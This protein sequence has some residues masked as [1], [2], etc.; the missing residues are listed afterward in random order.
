MV[1]ADKS[2]VGRVFRQIRR[3]LIANDGKP[4]LIRQLLDYITVTT[5]GISNN[6]KITASTHND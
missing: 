1:I 6:S 2:R 4:V 5:S 3:C